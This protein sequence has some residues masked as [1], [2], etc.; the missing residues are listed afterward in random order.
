MLPPFF[1][2]D[3]QE[4]NDL[5]LDPL[6]F[7]QKRPTRVKAKNQVVKVLTCTLLGNMLNANWMEQN[8]SACRGGITN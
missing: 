4:E 7:Y 2:A 5:G 3:L 8:N 1:L 6:S